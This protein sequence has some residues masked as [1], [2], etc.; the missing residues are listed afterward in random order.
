M[1]V[2]GNDKFSQLLMEFGLRTRSIPVLLMY[3]GEA[4]MDEGDVDAFYFVL[5]VTL[6]AY[7]E[8]IKEM[9]K[10]LKGKKENK[11]TPFDINELKLS[12]NSIS[13][14]LHSR[15]GRI[16]PAYQMAKIIRSMFKHYNVFIPRKAKSAATLLALAADEIYLT[17]IGELGP[18]DPIVSHPYSPDLMIPARA[19]KDF[20]EQ[21]LPALIKNYGP[22]VADYLLKIDYAHVGF[23]IQSTNSAK[24]YASRILVNYGL[25]GLKKKEERIRK[26]EK[27]I[28]ILMSYP[29]HD[30][31]IDY[32]EAKKIGLNVNLVENELEKLLWTIYSRNTKE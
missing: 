4:I 7:N 5:N 16:E 18:I 12:L 25:K 14:I 6:E 2:E 22:A 10:E 28:K 3:S 19:V 30:F 13:L 32:E 27:I 24:E 29:V 26:A 31:V 11:G 1:N 8:F 17:K 21:T 20:I 23:C 9:S 15:G